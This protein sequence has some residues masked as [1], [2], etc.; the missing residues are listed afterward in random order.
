M[1]FAYA[2]IAL[3]IWTLFIGRLTTI[4][5]FSNDTL[6]LTMAIVTAGGLAGGGDK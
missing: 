4:A 5:E 2:F 1:R 3:L 6:L